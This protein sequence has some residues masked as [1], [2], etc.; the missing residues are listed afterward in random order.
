MSLLSL[1]QL[2]LFRREQPLVVKPEHAFTAPPRVREFTADARVR[3]FTA[4]P[5]IRDFTA[6]A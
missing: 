2:N 5:R 4:P 1:F 6:G 3:D